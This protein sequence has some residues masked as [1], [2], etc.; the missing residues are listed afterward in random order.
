LGSM[1]VLQPRLRQ[2][3][4][5][6]Q[7]WKEEGGQACITSGQSSAR[8]AERVVALTKT[9]PLHTLQRTNSHHKKEE[10]HCKCQLGRKM[11]ADS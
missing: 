9:A 1:I 2:R 4:A 5:V 6:A 8:A 7:C 10:T 11:I 3:L